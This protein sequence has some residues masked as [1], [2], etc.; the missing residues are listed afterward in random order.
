MSE[1]KS[2]RIKLICSICG[3]HVLKKANLDGKPY[4]V[5]QKEPII[6]DRCVQQLADVDEHNQELLGLNKH[7]DEIIP[8]A[9]RIKKVEVKKK[10]KITDLNSIIT[11]IKKVIKGQDEAIK[12]IATAIYKNHELQNPELKSN[13]IVLGDS[14]SGKTKIIK[15]LTKILNIPYVIEDA[16]RY[17]EAGYVG[18]SVDSMLIDLYV[19][20]N[21][22]IESAQKGILV[23]DEGDKKSSSQD[24]G[25]DI[26]G[27][28][29]LFSLLKIVEGSKVPIKDEFGT[30]NE[31]FD[32]KNLTVIFI[33]A[34]PNLLKIREKRLKGGIGI[35]FSNMNN[36]IGRIEYMAEDFT[37]AGFPKEFIGRFD[38]II[39]L[40]TLTTS[41]YLNIIKNSSE[42]TFNLYSNLLK[43]RGISLVYEELLFT[44]IAEKAKKLNI[45]ARG[46]KHI[47]QDI[48]K[49]IIFETLSNKQVKYTKCTLLSDIINYPENYILE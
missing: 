10:S 27:E 32:T 35:G 38:T 11:D 47:V 5:R 12:F 40:N 1:N 6:C 49:E 4:A 15:M 22:D 31:Y 7:F 16:T 19:A 3:A 25:R 21:Y 34:F 14:G 23:I 48:F 18:D 46:I 39:E 28:S 43:K 9:N 36:Q 30:F 44:Q 2:V 13:L 8:N 42:S 45:G 26:S 33:G 41:D 37:N 24:T 20:A 29:V 17:T